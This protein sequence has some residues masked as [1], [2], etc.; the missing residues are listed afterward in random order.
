MCDPVTG[1]AVGGGLG[2]ASG[3][4]NQ[5]EEM[6]AKGARIDAQRRQKI[7]VVRSMNFADAQIHQEYRNLWDTTVAELGDMDLQ[8]MKNRTTMAAGISES[9]MEGR[10]TD[11][12]MR[13][14]I[15]QDLKAKARVDENYQRDYASI[16]GAQYSNWEQGKAQF[17]GIQEESKKVDWLA[18]TLKITSSGL[19]GAS[20]GS[21]MGGSIQ[22]ART[23]LSTAKAGGTS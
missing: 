6:K 8:A 13:A 11:A 14:T 20:S 3:I 16:L 10:T 22:S 5:K 9:G 2:V 19:S 7:E 23:K 18:E 17:K 12:I 4:M 21:Q 1:A 15:G